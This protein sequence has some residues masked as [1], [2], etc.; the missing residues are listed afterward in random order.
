VALPNKGMKLTKPERNGALQLIPGVRRTMQA[1][2]GGAMAVHPRRAIRVLVAVL[3]LALLASS[4]AAAVQEIRV[5]IVIPNGSAKLARQVTRFDDALRKSGARV[6]RANTLADADA[7]VQ[8][9]NY[10]RLIDDKGEPQDWWY[11]QF[12]LLKPPVRKGHGA[13]KTSPPFCLV[14]FGHDDWQVEPAV[15]LLGRTLAR[16]LGLEKSTKETE[17]SEGRA[18]EQRD[19]ADER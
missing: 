1:A 9:T 12:K 4:G 14:V 5:L 8:F 19:E 6:V 3:A 18:A 10:K 11:G 7:V 15:E 2:R 13:P 16:A 17:L